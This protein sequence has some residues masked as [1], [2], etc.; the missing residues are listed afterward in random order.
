[1]NTLITSDSS[2]REWLT[3][4]S[5]RY[6][7]SQIRAA[8]K[9]NE[10]L[11]RFYWQLGR[12][13][14]ERLPENK[15]GS[16]FFDKLSIDLS[17]ILPDIHSLSP[18]NLRYIKKF[19]SIYNQYIKNLPQLVANKTNPSI[20]DILHDIFQVPWG[21]HRFII[22]K[23]YHEPEK[24]LFFVQKTVENGWSRAMLL[25]FLDTDLYARQGKAITNFAKTLP[26]PTSE[27]AQQLT[28]DPYQ[29]D[30]LTISEQYKEKELKDALVDN[31]TKLLLELGTG[32]AFMGREYRM[33]AGEKEVFA[34]LLFYNTHLHCYVVAEVKVGDF[35][36]SHLGQLSAY[37]SIAD[38]TMKHAGDNQTIG[39]LICKNKDNVFAQYALEGY[40]QP[41]GI[42]E[43][44]LSS[45]QITKALPSIAEIEQRLR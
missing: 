2:Y 26:E 7:S 24:A 16:A 23:C 27:L 17:R 28:K 1:M 13:I 45:A 15:R 30:F 6:R 29:F 41:L 43:Y 11:L 25:N 4:L 36:A 34:D 21:H 14:V 35:E 5:K 3:E 32:F 10:E 22:D 37:V 40:R 31:I 38:A 8:V 19:Y 18:R 20:D 44:D 33:L 42:S 12:D 39:L 9:V